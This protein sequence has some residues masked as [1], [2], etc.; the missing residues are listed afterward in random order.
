MPIPWATSACHGSRSRVTSP[1]SIAAGQN[2]LP[3]RH[4]PDAGVGRVHARVQPAHEQAH[5][6]ADRVGQGAA[7]AEPVRRSRHRRRAARPPARRARTRRRR[8]TSRSRASRPRREPALGEVVV[9]EHAPSLQLPCVVVAAEERELHRCVV[10]RRAVQI[11]QR[12]RHVDRAEVDVGVAGPAAGQRPPPERQRAE[13][14]LER[15]HVGR[16]LP[17]PL[18]HRASAVERD[19]RGPQRRRV[20][21]RSAAEVDD[22]AGRASAAEGGGVGQQARGAPAL[23]AIGLGLV[24]GAV[25][26]SSVLCPLSTGGRSWEDTDLGRFFRGGRAARRARRGS[27]TGSHTRPPRGPAPRTSRRSSGM[28]RGAPLRVAHADRSRPAR[29]WTTVASCHVP[30]AARR[31]RTRSPRPQPD[32]EQ[33]A[34][35]QRAPASRSRRRASAPRASRIRRWSLR[36]PPSQRSGSAALRRT[37]SAPRG[38]GGSGTARSARPCDHRVGHVLGLDH[39][40]R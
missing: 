37:Y 15:R 3:G 12:H 1:A 33:R 38:G 17:R 13:V 20:P 10:L 19:R 26:G 23:V 7:P 34:V 25:A 9:G 27:A 21:T 18:D 14:G 8:A 6:R 5:V 31:K 39:A 11:G 2:R 24:D 22:R 28:A 32:L 35:G 36:M 40:L 4:E 30:P 29:G 16:P